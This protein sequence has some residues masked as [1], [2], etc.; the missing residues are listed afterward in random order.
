MIEVL[1]T[2]VI[3]EDYCHT[4][5]RYEICIEHYPEKSPIMYGQLLLAI[6][7]GTGY[8]TGINT[9]DY[10]FTRF[11]HPGDTNIDR[12]KCLIDFMTDARRTLVYDKEADHAFSKE[13]IDN[14]MKL[15]RYAKET[16]KA[17]KI[18]RRDLKIGVIHVE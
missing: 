17:G 18:R 5:L 10:I 12:Q 7:D 15:P 2:L 3:L 9:D 8:I 14:F 4:T 16:Y 1:D 13:L 11:H 6:E